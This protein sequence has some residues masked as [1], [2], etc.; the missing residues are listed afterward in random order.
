MLCSAYVCFECRLVYTCVHVSMRG[1]AYCSSLCMHVSQCI[2][3]VF[4]NQLYCVLTSREHALHIGERINFL[5]ASAHGAQGAT[6]THV[7][8]ICE[9]W[10][11]STR[12]CVAAAATRDFCIFNFSRVRVSACAGARCPTGRETT[13]RSCMSAYRRA[14]ECKTPARTWT[15][16]THT[17]VRRTRTRKYYATESRADVHRILCTHIFGI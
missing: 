7:L 4:D 5:C 12:A 11:N 3:A 8:L 9:D 1:S 14:Y 10:F 15:H 6:H 17:R 13:F 16:K 2:V